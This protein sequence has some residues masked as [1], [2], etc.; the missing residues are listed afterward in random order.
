MKKKKEKNGCKTLEQYYGENEDTLYEIYLCTQL[1]LKST[2]VPNKN[3]RQIIKNI[4][5]Y[6]ISDC[7]QYAI[8]SEAFVVLCCFKIHSVFVFHL[9]YVML[10]PSSFLGLHIT[11]QLCK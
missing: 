6:K 7:T 10:H 8:P 1:R 3:T 11:T 5:K 2:F 4:I 9:S